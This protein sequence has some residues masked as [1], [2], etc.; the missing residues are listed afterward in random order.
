MKY[1]DELRKKKIE[2]IERYLPPSD[3]RRRVIEEVNEGKV[4]SVSYAKGEYCLQLTVLYY[5]GGMSV[6]NL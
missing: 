2:L 6:F 1:N 3:E 4:E 5:S